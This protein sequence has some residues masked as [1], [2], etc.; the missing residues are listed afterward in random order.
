MLQK[1]NH[2]AKTLKMKQ[3]RENVAK[4]SKKETRFYLYNL[5]VFNM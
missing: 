4:C 3:G 2:V 1:Q 5:L